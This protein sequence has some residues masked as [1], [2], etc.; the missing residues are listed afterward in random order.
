[1]YA[2][3][4]GRYWCVSC[5]PVC[6]VCFFH[7]NISEYCTAERVCLHVLCINVLNSFV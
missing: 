4:C 7:V 6:G 5:V 2:G 1:M 3:A